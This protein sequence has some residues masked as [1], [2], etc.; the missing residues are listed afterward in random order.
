M[1]I[2]KLNR[3]E[4]AIDAVLS[5]CTGLFTITCTQSF[6][7]FYEIC[8]RERWDEDLKACLLGLSQP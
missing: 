2:R 4:V 3:S 6:V 7:I 1:C 8:G 5:C